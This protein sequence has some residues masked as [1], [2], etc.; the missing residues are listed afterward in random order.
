MRHGLRDRQGSRQTGW[1]NEDMAHFEPL[2]DRLVVLI[3]GAGFLGTLVAQELLKRGARVRIADRH[4]EKAFRLKPLANLGQIQFARCSVTH[5]GSMEAAISGAYAVVYL[6]GTFGAGQAAL[7]ADGAGL[8]ARIATEQGVESFAYVS[9]I[10]ADPASQSG[11]AS[12][13]GQGEEQVRAAFPRASVLR[14]SVLFGEDD[15]FINLFAGVIRTFPI[16]PVFA[17]EAKLQPLWV[18]DAANAVVNALAEPERHG[19]KIFEIAGP[20]VL[21]MMELHRQIARAQARERLLVPVPDGLANL[22]AALPG[23]PL[24]S[25]QLSLLRKGSVA[26]AELP[27]CKQLGIVPRPLE[28]FLDRWMTRYRKYGRFTETAETA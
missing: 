17:P 16:V 28:L 26:S 11:Y 19:G 14:P 10:G 3:G 4:P 1:L 21:T 5:A 12:T 13:K 22:F 7:Q 25:D 15:N 20:E 18:E 2:E 23:T 6:V 9:A 8:A 24:G 27:G